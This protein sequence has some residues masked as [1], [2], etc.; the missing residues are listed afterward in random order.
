MDGV[1]R[2][3]DGLAGGLD[4]IDLPGE[5]GQDRLAGVLTGHGARDHRHVQALL[6]TVASVS[7]LAPLPET[8][9][10]VVAEDRSYMEWLAERS[11]FPSDVRAIARAALRGSFPERDAIEDADEGEESPESG[12]GES[13]PTLF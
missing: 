9:Q 7:R 12:R 5:G 3:P 4:P 8:L 1:V 11:D 2:A 10:A 6:D 13:S